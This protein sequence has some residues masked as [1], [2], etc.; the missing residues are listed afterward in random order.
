MGWETVFDCVIKFSKK[1]GLGHQIKVGGKA[2]RRGK[3][4]DFK[5]ERFQVASQQGAGRALI[6]DRGT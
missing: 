6:L 5:K 4:R 2:V 1:R 3:L